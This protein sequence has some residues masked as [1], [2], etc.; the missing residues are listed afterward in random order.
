MNRN[1]EIAQ[2]ALDGKFVVWAEVDHFDADRD[3]YIKNNLGV[4]QMWIPVAVTFT[5]ESAIKA[6]KQLR[7]QT[8]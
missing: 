8:G 5:K 1:Y 6:I 2:R 4:P 7:G 3:W